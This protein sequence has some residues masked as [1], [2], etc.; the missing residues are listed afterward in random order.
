MSAL[1]R[2]V[3]SK[4]A[5]RKVRAVAAEDSEAAHALFDMIA[6]KRTRWEE[7]QWRT[8]LEALDRCELTVG[9]W[10]ARQGGS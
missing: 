3:L 5:R 1:A 7:S 2:E 8:V 6:S 9:E 10:L 4:H